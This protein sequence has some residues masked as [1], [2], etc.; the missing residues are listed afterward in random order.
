MSNHKLPGRAAR[1]AQLAQLEEKWLRPTEKALVK[2][3]KKPT[4]RSVQAQHKGAVKF[5]QGGKVSPR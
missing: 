3:G 1:Q 5:V 2:D 4:R